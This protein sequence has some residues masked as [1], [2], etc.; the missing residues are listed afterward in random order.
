MDRLHVDQGIIAGCSG[1]MYDNIAEA[2]ADIL[3]GQ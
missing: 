3:D 1:G 2:A